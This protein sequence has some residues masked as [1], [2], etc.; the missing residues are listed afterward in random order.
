MTRPTAPMTS[1][2]SMQRVGTTATPMQRMPSRGAVM[3]NQ[4]ASMY[5]RVSQPTTGYGGYTTPMTMTPT[6]TVASPRRLS[7]VPNTGMLLSTQLA[8][9]LL[10]RTVDPSIRAQVERIQSDAAKPEELKVS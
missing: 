3:T 1:A 7:S 9:Q 10:S 5:R 8:T 4:A 6:S 2:A